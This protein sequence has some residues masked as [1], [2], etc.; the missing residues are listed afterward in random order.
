M[1]TVKQENK[2]EI[3]QRTEMKTEPDK[4]SKYQDDTKTCHVRNKLCIRYNKDKN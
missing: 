1:N 4:V 3:R 2:E